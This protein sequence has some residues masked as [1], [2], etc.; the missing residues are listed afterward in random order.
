M[1]KIKGLAVLVVFVVMAAFAY[2]Q[3]YGWQ[4]YWL[5]ISTPE[6]ES[7]SG[8]Q[9]T[10]YDADTSNVAT[11]ATD[12]TASETYITQP[13][14]DSRGIC[15]FWYK[16]TSCDVTI[17]E[18]PVSKNV[19]KVSGLTP[20][21]HKVIFYPAKFDSFG[22]VTATSLNAT[23]LKGVQSGTFGTVT[24]TSLN[25]TTLKGV[26]SGTA[27]GGTITFDRKYLSAPK[28][29]FEIET[30]SDTDVLRDVK[31]TDNSSTE[32][33]TYKVIS[34]NGSTFSDATDTDTIIWTAIGTE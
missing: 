15:S 26:Q 17:T 16:G 33:A 1:K 3:M 25:A 29:F 13:T 5:S 28:V 8:V 21:S 9:V 32:T 14:V 18:T 23:T 7:C 6:G 4:R 10:V 27:I 11:L 19:I 22:T 12:R 20:R 31:L 34:Y 24:A 2:A 30:D